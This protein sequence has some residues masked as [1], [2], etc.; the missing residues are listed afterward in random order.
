MEV[1]IQF[2]NTQTVQESS[3]ASNLLPENEALYLHYSTKINA[4][5][6]TVI[7]TTGIKIVDDDYPDNVWILLSPTVFQ[8]TK[9]MIQVNL[10][11]CILYRINWYLF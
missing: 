3:Q 6:E 5:W 1:D 10:Y 2:K 9:K 11:V 8:Q 7:A 4:L